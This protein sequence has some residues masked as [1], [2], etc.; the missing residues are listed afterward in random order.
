MKFYIEDR[1]YKLSMN[2][3]LAYIGPMSLFSLMM[4]CEFIVP[5]K[6]LIL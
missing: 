4:K 1:Y 5:Q 2:L 3:V 6:L